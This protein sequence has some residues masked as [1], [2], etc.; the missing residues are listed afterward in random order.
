VKIINRYYN[1]ADL[2]NITGIV[3]GLAAAN[4]ESLGYTDAARL[5]S[6]SG[7]YGTRSW[8]YDSNGNRTSETANGVVDTYYYVTNSNRLSNIARNATATRIFT[9]DLAGNVIQDLRGANAYNYAVNNAGRIRQMSLNTGAVQVANYTY[10][11]F[12]KLRVKTLTSPAQTTHYVWDTFGHVIAETSGSFTREYIWL[13]DT[14]LAINEGATLSYVHPDHLDRPIAMTTSGGPAVAWS[15]KYD[16]FGNVVTITNP[17]AM[18]LRFPGQ[19]FQ[20]EDGLS[21]N[22]HRNY[23]PTLGRYSQADPLGFVDGPGVYNYAGGSPAMKV[24]PKG[25]AEAG[26]IVGGGIGSLAGSR[27]GPTGSAI[28]RRLGAAIG[29]AIQDMCTPDDDCPKHR[30][31]A[32]QICIDLHAEGENWNPRRFGPNPHSIERCMMGYI[33]ARCGGNPVD[34]GGKPNP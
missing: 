12:Q 30:E 7:A 3:D 33:P 24:D 13:G 2:T 10:D 11:G 28:G 29:S 6:A 32:R 1:R 20:I 9:Y 14:P 17:T 21:Y 18:P 34:W 8:T 22:W 31:I 4:N 19:Y 26:A 5:S 25:L 23:D 16:P 15:A 27:F